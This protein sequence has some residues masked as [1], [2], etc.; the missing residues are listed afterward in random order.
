MNSYQTWIQVQ[1]LSLLLD[2]QIAHVNPDLWGGLKNKQER[3]F[4]H[5]A[6]FLGDTQTSQQYC[7]VGQG[8][9]TPPFHG[10]ITGSSPVR[11]TTG[12]G[13]SIAPGDG[14]RQFGR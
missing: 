12:M 10:G 13:A 5:L 7:R 8:V 11:G 6:G 4:A 9:K 1:V 2:Q 14:N 3:G